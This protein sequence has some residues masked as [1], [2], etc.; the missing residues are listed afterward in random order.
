MCHLQRI[1]FAPN[2]VLQQV[3]PPYGLNSLQL[4]AETLGLKAGVK[5]A[6]V[7]DFAGLPLPCLAVLKPASVAH[8]IEAANQAIAASVP[9]EAEGE[10]EVPPPHRLVLVLKADDARVLLFDEKSK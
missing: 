7:G 3:A 2:L 10:P 5:T 1:P 6:A 4:A 9:S 8:P